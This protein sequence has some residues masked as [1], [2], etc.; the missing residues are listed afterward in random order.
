MRLTAKD[1]AAIEQAAH[2]TF[3]PRSTI[4]LFG[5]RPDDAQ[6]G[7]D[8]DLLVELPAPL[9]PQELVARRNRFVAR[10][11]SLL[12]ERRIDVLIVAAG[13]PDTWNWRRIPSA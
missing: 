10:L 11:Y 7:G 12:G 4:R 5:S 9:T 6:R 3:P 1:I 2:E 8:S 13:R